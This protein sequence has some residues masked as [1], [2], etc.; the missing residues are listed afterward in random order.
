MRKFFLRLLFCL[1]LFP[2]G[3]ACEKAG[4]NETASLGEKGFGL[5]PAQGS[6]QEDIIIK[7]VFTPTLRLKIKSEFSGRL[8]NL[9]VSKGQ[10]I[11]VNSPLARIEDDNLPQELSDLRVQLQAAET[12]LE[13]NE[14]LAPLEASEAEEETALQIEAPRTRYEAPPYQEPTFSSL[15]SEIRFTPVD[16][17]GIWPG[18]DPRVIEAAENDPQDAGGIWPSYGVREMVNGEEGFSILN[19]NEI[20]LAPRF[21]AS[22]VTQ[23]VELRSEEETQAEAKLS[24]APSLVFLY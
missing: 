16:A 3:I 23:P 14:R 7:G 2:L 20:I 9:S 17:G 18:I 13:Q 5:E 24:E 8:E 10:I 22:T 4:K 15:A 21:I 19:I 12:Q 11:S 1:I 6:S